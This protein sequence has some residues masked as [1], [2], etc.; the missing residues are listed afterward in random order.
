MFMSKTFVVATGELLCSLCLLYSPTNV[1]Y[2]LYN[3][4]V[5]SGCRYQFNPRS[6]GAV[7]QLRLISTKDL[8]VNVSVS[9]A[10]TIIQAYSSWN[11]LSNVHEYHKERVR[12]FPLVLLGYFLSEADLFGFTFSFKGVISSFSLDLRLLLHTGSISPS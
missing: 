9:N 3:G 12:T 7:S 4:Y 6:F 1:E 2:I 10:N 5:P 11:S 8:N